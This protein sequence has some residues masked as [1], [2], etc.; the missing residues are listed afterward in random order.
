MFIHLDD[1]LLVDEMD[2]IFNN[3]VRAVRNLAVAA[4]ENKHILYGDW[5]VIVAMR[6]H[7]RYD[8]DVWDVLNSIYQLY[9]RAGCPMEVSYYLR[10]VKEVGEGGFDENGKRYEPISYTVFEDTKATQEC[11]LISEDF[12]DCVFYRQVV[13]Y[14]KKQ[15]GIVLPCN[16]YNV[17]GSG[18]RTVENVR[19]CVFENKQVS[20]CIVDTDKKYPEQGLNRKKACYKCQRIGKNVPSYLFVPL[21]VQEVENLVPFNVLEFLEWNAESQ[22]NKD[23]FCELLNK[24]DTEYVVAYFDIKKGIVKDEL[25]KTDEKYMNYAKICFGLNPEPTAHGDFDAY[26][27]GIPDEG[28]VYRHL[29]A[30]LLKRYL[31]YVESDPSFKIELLEYQKREWE[32][33]SKAMLTMGCSRGK[34]A[35][36]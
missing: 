31:E 6:Q 20:I 21:D 14:Y 32:K 8:K 7:F 25:L 3:V 10:V 11:N 12:N 34:E 35:I 17:S 19:K 9:H 29:L 24:K 36:T 33:I 4:F 18:E 15:K 5:N 23:A 26:V 30:G 28:V 2:P 27:E 16:F 13:D 1:S 22:K